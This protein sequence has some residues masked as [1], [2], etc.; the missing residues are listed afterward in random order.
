VI[1]GANVA[2]ASLGYELA[3]KGHE[4]ILLEHLERSKIGALS[5]GDGVDKL[6]FERLGLELED[7]DW[8]HGDVIRGEVFAPD[9]KNS[10]AAQG[11]IRAVHRYHFCQH[12]V[13]RAVN[14]GAKLIDKAKAVAPIIENNFVKGIRYKQ[15]TGNSLKT[16]SIKAKI[17]VDASGLNAAVRSKL[18]EDWMVA[19]KID[20]RDI[21]VCYKESRE[22]S[23]PL[24]NKFIHGFFSSEIAPGG[25][26]WIATRSLTKV[27]V[28]LGL[29]YEDDP[30]KQLNPKKQ[31]YNKI[32]KLHPFIKKSTVTW[33]GGGLIPRRRPLD[34]MV[35]NGFIAVGDAGAMVNPMSGGGIGPSMYAGKLGGKV[36]HQALKNNDVS[37]EYLWKF[38]FEYNQNYGHVQA[39]NQILRLTIESLTDNQINALLGANL[40]SETELIEAIE[41]GKLDIGFLSKLKK[42]GKLTRHPKLLMTLRRMYKG[43]ERA[44]EIY[45]QYPE[46][47]QDIEKW[48]AETRKFFN[49]YY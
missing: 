3:W 23:K 12:L 34:C 19:E 38:N 49:K 24:K 25:F 30:G 1:V 41:S 20:R 31:L 43:M 46:S 18:P 8:V 40:F 33:S 28:G 44:R 11:Y 4:V 14:A 37:L 42:V 27:N 32:M 47:H 6:E 45:K 7:G 15:I 13:D 48:Q 22:F 10:L 29:K 26:Y 16:R 5:C 2:G 35:G 9:M 36:I 39:S 21:S 17:V